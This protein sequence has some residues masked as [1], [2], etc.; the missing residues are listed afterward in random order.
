MRMLVLICRLTQNNYQ[1]MI[2]S[3]IDTLQWIKET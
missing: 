2:M 3:Q 1:I